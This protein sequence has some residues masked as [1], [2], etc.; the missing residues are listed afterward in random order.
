MP[1]VLIIVGLALVLDAVNDTGYTRERFNAVINSGYYRTLLILVGV[2]F[3]HN[4]VGNAQVRRALVGLAVLIAL[5]T[6]LYRE[7]NHG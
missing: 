5:G 2:L 7:S 3:V 4:N 6:A 1:I